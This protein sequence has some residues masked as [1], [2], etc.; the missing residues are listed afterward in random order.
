MH[1]N[2][3]PTST[4]CFRCHTFTSGQLDPVQRDCITCHIPNPATPTTTINPHGPSVHD[5]VTHCI[6][7]DSCGNCH[8]GSLPDI[9]S[10]AGSS[11]NSYSYHGGSYGGN[12]VN[13]GKSVCY[14]CHTSTN[15]TVQQTVIKGLAGQTVSCSDCH[16]SGR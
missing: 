11:G 6:V 12:S 1:H 7:Y 8:K 16:D 2:L 4:G 10:G 14:L 3:P 13:P 15:K 5:K 9:H